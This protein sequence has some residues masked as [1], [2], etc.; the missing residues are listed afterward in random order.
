MDSLS[1]SNEETMTHD[2]LE[3]LKILKISNGTI[4]DGV[5]KVLL[6]ANYNGS[7]KFSIKEAAVGSDETIYGKVGHIVQF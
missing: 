1:I 7:L 4:A 3:I 5:S 6:I 2:I